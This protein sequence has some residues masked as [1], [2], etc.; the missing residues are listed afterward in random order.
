MNHLENLTK[1]S[2]EAVIGKIYKVNGHEKQEIDPKE[3]LIT[4]KDSNVIDIDIII[5]ISD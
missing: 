1:T 3:L 4:E 5:N 2:V